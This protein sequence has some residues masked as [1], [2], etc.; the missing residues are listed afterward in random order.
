MHF[1]KVGRYLQLLKEVST[2][3]AND[4]GEDKEVS[5]KSSYY[6]HTICRHGSNPNCFHPFFSD[7]LVFYSILHVA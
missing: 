6:D 7:L 3:T 1:E 4:E 5:A 2:Q